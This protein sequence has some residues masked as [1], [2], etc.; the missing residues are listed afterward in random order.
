[1]KKYAI[2]YLPKAEED[3]L[4]LQKSGDKQAIKKLDKL[5]NELREHPTY[6]EGKPERLKHNIGDVWSREITR[7]HRLVYE[8]FE[9]TI[10]VEV[11]Q[12]WGHYKDK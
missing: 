1:M 10:L 9:D 5:L 8:I 3:I 2:K 4:K 6:G 12:A 11:T 7:K